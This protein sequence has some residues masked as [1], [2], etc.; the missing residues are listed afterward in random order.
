MYE[1]GTW[2]VE[3]QLV[4]LQV[5][6]V[7]RSWYLHPQ[8]EHICASALYYYSSSNITESRLSFRQLSDNQ[9]R[10][11]Y[12]QDHHDWLE[13]V[14]G[15]Q[16]EESSIQYIGDVIT[17]EGRVVT[18]PNVFQHQVQPFE[19]EDQKKPGHR[20]IL[21]LFLIDPHLRIISSANVPAQ[22]RD[23]W[24][25]EIRSLGVFP[26]LPVEIH[27]E[28]IDYVDDFPLSLEDA[29]LLRLEL[30]EGRKAFVVQHDQ[31]FAE[32]TFSLC[33]H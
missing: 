10:F 6:Y 21:A 13:A 30:M 5:N 7:T 9:P 17:K 32:T 28:V 19:L 1:G 24:A 2:H 11:I 20:K 31:K 25:E 4:G 29:N 14:F 22:Q 33:E 16:N 3:G 15:C 27:K 23:W 8:N 18:F 12:P 26:Q